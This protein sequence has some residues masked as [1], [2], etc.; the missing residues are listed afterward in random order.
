MSQTQTEQ[1]LPHTDSIESQ[2]PNT[3]D[4]KKKA[5]NRRPASTLLPYQSAERWKQRATG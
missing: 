1:P 4:K 3:K 5:K 2:D